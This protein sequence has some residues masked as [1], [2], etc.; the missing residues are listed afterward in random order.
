MLLVC[1]IY[2]VIRY[3]EYMHVQYLSDTLKPISAACVLVGT[4]YENVL[5][6]DEPVEVL[7]L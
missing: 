6:V 7:Q 5:Q 3:Q 2:S 1:I 4:G